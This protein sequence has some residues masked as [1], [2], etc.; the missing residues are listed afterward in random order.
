[1]PNC[2]IGYLFWLILLHAQFLDAGRDVVQRLLEDRAEFIGR[3][4]SGDRSAVFDQCAIVVGRDDRH[5]LVVQHLDNWRWCS[6]SGT[7]AEPA[8]SDKINT[9]LFER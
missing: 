8:E 4:R 9:L 1:M 3:R 2:D 7:D 6:G 5:D